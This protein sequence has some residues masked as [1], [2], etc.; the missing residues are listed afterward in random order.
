MAIARPAARAP[1]MSNGSLSPTIAVSAG[2][3][4]SSSHARWNAAGSGLATPSSAEIATASTASPMPVS[5]SLRRCQA[6]GP[7]VRIPTASPAD[8]AACSVRSCPGSGAMVSASAFDSV[9]YSRTSGAIG[10]PHGSS[11]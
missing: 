5:S 1:A 7:L 4:P 10:R 8:R 9:R 2:A 3:T 11:A 6:D